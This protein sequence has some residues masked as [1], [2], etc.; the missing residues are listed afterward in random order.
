MCEALA[1]YTARLTTLDG[2]DLAIP[3]DF[4]IH[5]RYEEVVVG[6]GMPLL[7]DPNKKGN[8]KIRFNIEFP[9]SLKPE[10]KKIAANFFS[11]LE[12]EG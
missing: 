1:G 6:E 8:L 4:I 9:S 3:I 11:Q 10:Q 7:K 2:R 12:D 5:P